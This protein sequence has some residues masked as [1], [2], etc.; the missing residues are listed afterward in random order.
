MKNVLRFLA[1]IL[2]LASSASAASLPSQIKGAA[3]LDTVETFVMPTQ[4]NAALL[5]AAPDTGMGPFRF[6]E[7]IGTAIDAKSDGTWETLGDGSRLW[8]ARIFSTDAQ[9]L[10]I[11]FIP[12]FMPAGGELYIY[13]P[14]GKEIY[15]PFTA[16]DNEKHRQL[17]TPIVDG[18]E[19]VIEVNL[20]AKAEKALQL[21]VAQVSHGF[22]TPADA[23]GLR[24]G[25]CNVDVICPEGDGWRDQISSVGA[26][27][28][29]GIDTCSGAAVNNTAN[30]FT[31]YFLTANHCGINSS[32]APSI[33]VYWNYENSTCRP[34]GSAASGS[35]GDGS[36]SQYNTGAIYRA[37]Y[38][39][40]DF[41]LFE[42]DDP[43]PEAYD[44][45]RSGWDVTDVAPPSVVGIHHPSVE[46]KRI[47]FEND[48]TTITDYLDTT[49]NANSTHI[50]ITDW[51]LGTTEGG[52]SGS[53]LFNPDH[54]IV[55]VLT[56]GYAACGNDSSD[57]YGR[58]YKS[59]EGGGSST[60]RLKDW[61]DPGNTGA[62]AIDGL[63]T[64]AFAKNGDPVVDD[65]AGDG[66]GII[67]R[68]ES[69]ILLTM[70][71]KNTG[72]SAI[73]GISGTLSS[74]TS[75]VTV[76]QAS[77]QFPDLASGANGTNTTAYAISVDSTVPCG[78]DI[79]LQLAI[80]S[81]SETATLTYTIPTGPNCDVLPLP[82]I[83]DWAFSDGAGNNNGVIE[84][85][86]QIFMNIQLLSTEAT[87]QNITAVLSTTDPNI[88]VQTN[89]ATYPDLANGATANGSIPFEFFV[90]ADRP[91]GDQIDFSLNLTYTGGSNVESL[92]LKHPSSG[93]FSDDFEG[94]FDAWTTSAQQGTNRWAI[95]TSTAA[96]SG[97]H[98][99]SFD[100]PQP[101]IEDVRLVAGPFTSATQLEF[102][103]RYYFEEGFDGGV[104]EIS[105][106]G[107]TSWSQLTSEITSGGYDAT[108]PSEY[109]SP[110]GGMS[111]W[112]GT[113]ASMSKVAV[114]LSSYADET[115]HLAWRWGSDSSV[116]SD[117]PWEIDDV[118]VNGASPCEPVV[119]VH[120]AEGWMTH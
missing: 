49:V 85:G 55:A 17:W 5:K 75:G 110:I 71:I 64:G 102:Y 87:A 81:A 105:T 83:N 104:L 8:R 72:T 107:G 53:P 14:D 22:R 84:P 28:I 45:F 114:D 94:T 16:A 10:N 99:V 31:P 61:L 113:H 20:P 6:A 11:G 98:V 51:D 69:G 18:E 27:T 19:L 21:E 59:W 74:Q 12:Y 78:N 32:N 112:T 70:S 93:I 33:V 117:G 30:D 63:G 89:T 66:D 35:N 86:E 2:I 24:S 40:S 73:T 95:R 58:L 29:Q 36:R 77:S 79:K 25:S 56:G 62:T 100:P 38:E 101:E 13:S 119:T 37:S 52:S 42:L 76:D 1:V 68:G 65:S 67:E 88:T 97:T 46:E 50:R 90:S 26:Y 115:I 43:I 109:G 111:A 47:S 23:L 54:R 48:Q 15:G 34:V 39:S 106:N 120:G 80:V 3:P 7:P 9:N 82:V 4:N 92:A 118:V 96:V 116:E 60:S 41:C 108:I 57:W 91:C 103:H 44:I